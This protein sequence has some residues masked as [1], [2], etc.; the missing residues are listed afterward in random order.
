MPEEGSSSAASI[1]ASSTPWVEKYRPASIRDVVHQEQ[2]VV[3]LNNAIATGNVR[4]DCGNAHCGFWHLFVPLRA[5][6]SVFVHLIVNMLSVA[7]SALLWSSWYWQ[8]VFDPCAGKGSFRTRVVQGARVGVER[9][10]R[11]R[12][13][14]CT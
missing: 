4:A 9:L 2:V 14:C 5:I 12:N 11:T 1:R 10:G 3:T 7:A 6:S 8:D 13:R